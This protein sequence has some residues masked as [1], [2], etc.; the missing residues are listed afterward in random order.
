MWQKKENPSKNQLGDKCI[1]T[2]LL[3]QKQW[4]QSDFICTI[5]TPGDTGLNYHIVNERHVHRCIC[6]G[7][8]LTVLIHPSVSL[9]YIGSILVRNL[10]LLGI[11]FNYFSNCAPDVSLDMYTLK[12]PSLQN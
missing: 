5:H 7:D 12:Y 3:H 10:H 8:L 11:T 9:A 4:L 1:F 2:E 6:Y